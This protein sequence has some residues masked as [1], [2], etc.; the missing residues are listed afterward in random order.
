MLTPTSFATFTEAY[1]AVIRT[2]LEQPDHRT[3]GRGKDAWET[4]NV[5]FQ[6]DDPLNRL[7][8]LRSRRVNP[9]FNYAE[10]LWYLSGSNDL[11]MIA[12]YAPRLRKLSTDG[13]TMTGTAYGPRLFAPDPTGITQFDRVLNLVRAERDSKRSAMIIM[14]PDEL[15]DPGNPDVACTLAVQLM[16]RD[17][18]LYMSTYMR[19]NDTK[20]GLPCDLFS[21]TM[22]QEF[23]ARLLGVPVGTY[24]HHAGSMHINTLDLDQVHRMVAEADAGL[25]AEL[26]PAEVMP[27]NTTWDTIHTLLQVEDALRRDTTALPPPSAAELPLAPYWQRVLL[28]FE[29]YRQITHTDRPVTPDVLE[30]LDPGHRWLLTARWPDR[31]PAT[32]GESQ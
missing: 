20:I 12:Y 14:R 7:P 23:A 15:A 13:R 25:Q 32:V 5:S 17:G 6:L 18:R 16:L 31:M 27:E 24:T 10:F 21:F 28:L 3:V 4:R 9:V 11:D 29:A 19:G 22:I 2:V 30:A 8:Y 1:L 26:F